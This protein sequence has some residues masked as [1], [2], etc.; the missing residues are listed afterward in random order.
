M[1]ASASGRS[2]VHRNCELLSFSSATGRGFPVVFSNFQ[3]QAGSQA[4]AWST[5][6]SVGGP[7]GWKMLE[8]ARV[9]VA[10][11]GPPQAGALCFVLQGNTGLVAVMHG[12][13]SI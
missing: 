8:V 2:N 5:T 3:S 9:R 12:L 1:R 6:I 7:A 11:E 10:W 4:R 13:C